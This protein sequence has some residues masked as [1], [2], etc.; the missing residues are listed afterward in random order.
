MPVNSNGH[1][2][3]GGSALGADHAFIF[4]GVAVIR[5]LTPSMNPPPSS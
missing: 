2:T 3:S 4:S 1:G 5:C